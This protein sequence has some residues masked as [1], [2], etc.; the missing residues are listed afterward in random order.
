MPKAQKY[1]LG[2]FLSL[3]VFWGC[4]NLIAGDQTTVGIDASIQAE[5]LLKNGTLIRGT[6]SVSFRFKS[7]E[8]G[9]LSIPVQRMHSAMWQEDKKAVLVQ[10]N[11]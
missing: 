2:L 8:A 10:L 4:V 1:I 3:F 9:Q 7:L 5:L 6:P 11:N